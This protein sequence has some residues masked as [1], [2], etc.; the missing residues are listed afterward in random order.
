MK[1]KIWI[2]LG[3]VIVLLGSI[4]ILIQNEN[5]TE[6]GKQEQPEPA[7]EQTYKMNQD[8]RVQEKTVMQTKALSENE[9]YYYDLDIDGKNEKIEYRLFGNGNDG[10]EKQ[11]IV[12]YINDEEAYRYKMG[13]G[14]Y[15]GY[16]IADI[17]AGD[18]YLD[19]FLMVTSDSYCLEY[20]AFLQYQSKQIK[21][22]TSS[23][24][25][26]SLQFIRGYEIEGADGG[27]GFEAAIDTPFPLRAIGCYYCYV[28]FVMEEGTVK[29]KE[30]DTYALA[31]HSREFRYILTQDIEVYEE[32]DTSSG[33]SGTLEEGEYVTIS[34]IKLNAV[35][36][37]QEENAPVSGY[38]CIEDRNGKKGWIYLDGEYDWDNPLFE[39]IPAWG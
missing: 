19:L 18:G 22:L 27:G 6:A 9:M 2:S 23:L 28:P 5:K 39:E 14:L 24:D 7:A 37:E 38:A 31:G 17:D 4:G 32:A 1:A 8:I 10:Q 12:L 36:G 25:N 35:N 13:N 11:E 3:I 33:V 30:T 16:T 20:A 15:A 34:E 26:K 29:R 21:T